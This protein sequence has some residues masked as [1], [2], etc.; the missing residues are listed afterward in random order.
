MEAG[1]KIFN[2][3]IYISYTPQ[4]NHYTVKLFTKCVTQVEVSIS[5]VFKQTKSTGHKIKKT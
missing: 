1:R 5:K 4:P 3:T 2:E